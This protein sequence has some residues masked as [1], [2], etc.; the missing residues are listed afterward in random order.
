[1]ILPNSKEALHRGQLYKILIEIADNPLL[2]RSLI[3]KGGT[4]AAMQNYL[5]R[6]SVDLD[7]DLKKDA[8]KD[9]VKKGLEKTFKKL[10]FEVKSKSKSTVQYVL[11]Y[12]APAGLRNTLKFDAVD[13]VLDADIFKPI[14]LAD[15]DR[16]LVCQTI[17]TMFGHKLAA[18]LDRYEKHGAIAGRDIYD[19]YYFFINV[20]SYNQKAIEQRTSLSV[21]AYLEKLKEFIKSKV[22]TSIIDED[23]NMLMP[24]ARFSAIRKSLKSEVLGLLE[25]E[26]N[27]LVQN[28]KLKVKS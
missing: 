10:N 18:V 8:A 24:L 13:F 2:S 9:L 17:E 15:I 16:Y 14:Y 21:L 25:D 4:C 5:D 3:F 1:M 19:I 23:L 22:N 12:P 27:R 20:H 26:I 7:F 6:F 28:S 11:K